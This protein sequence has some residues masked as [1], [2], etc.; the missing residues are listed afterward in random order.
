MII[1]SNS[2]EIDMRA[3]TTF[4]LSVKESDSAIGRFGTGLKYAIAVVL[5]NGGAI[6]VS[7]GSDRYSF[8][9][10][11]DEFRGERRQF[12]FMCR[13]GAEAAPLGFTTDLGRDWEDWQ[14]FREFYANNIDE[15]G[16]MAHRDSGRP[17]PENGQT[18]IAIE[19]R[20][21]DAIFYALEEHFIGSGEESLWHNEEIEVYEG[22][23]KYVFYQGIRV[24]ELKKPAAYRYNIKR[25]LELT[26]DRTA[27]YGWQVL[28][29]ITQNLPKCTSTD[30]CESVIAPTSEFERDLDYTEDFSGTPSA[31]FAGAV[32][33][34]KG[35]CP[36]SAAQIVRMTL[37]EGTDELSVASPEQKG[38]KQLNIAVKTAVNAGLDK[39]GVTFV[40]GIGLPVVGDY[41]I[42][43][44]NVI[45]SESILED[46]DA[47][48]EAVVVALAELTSRSPLSYLARLLIEKTSAENAHSKKAAA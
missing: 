4:G 28:M 39:S 23:S 33:A 45:L 26:E 13:N 19:H 38:S 2:G 6:H 41:A 18:I 37:P 20:P 10:R 48:N 43:E 8:E 17:T 42:R 15:D 40:L 32:V 3:V 12:V 27:K 5:R 1:F 30:I 24:H 46:Q 22:R 44:K 21:F 35:D 25:Y 47:M 9:L 7:S 31:E 11:E 29:R 14:A 36:L 34:S 16:Q